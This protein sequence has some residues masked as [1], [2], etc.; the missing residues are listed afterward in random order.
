MARSWR[1]FVVGG[2]AEGLGGGV[3]GA[4]V[5]VAAGAVAVGGVAEVADEGG[6][7][8]LRGFGEGDHAVDLGA[9]EG[10]LRRRSRCAR[11]CCLEVRRCARTLPSKSMA[12]APWATEFF[13]GSG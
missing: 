4:E 8:A 1:V 12:A 2:G 9:A 10:E 5:A 11:I 3:G 7:A 6:H 13:D